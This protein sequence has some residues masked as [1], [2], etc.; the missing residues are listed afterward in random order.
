MNEW[1]EVNEVTE[2]GRMWELSDWVF[3]HAEL[4]AWKRPVVWMFTHGP[5]LASKLQRSPADTSVRLYSWPCSSDLPMN[6]T[7]PRLKNAGKRVKERLARPSPL[8]QSLMNS[9][10]CGLLENLLFQ[11]GGETEST[12]ALLIRIH[13][14]AASKTG[15][16]QPLA[17]LTKA[18]LATRRLLW[19]RKKRFPLMLKAHLWPTTK[20]RPSKGDSPHLNHA[21][22]RWSKIRRCCFRSF[23]SL[24]RLHLQMLFI[25]RSS[26]LFKLLLVLLD[27][28]FV[29]I[30]ASFT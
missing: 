28:A 23:K 14:R 15:S 11:P 20:T 25:Q 13:L 5:H 26:F 4:C 21:H 16:G 12:T 9:Q 19:K 18:P 2:R 8:L 17:C 22:N 27:T 6:T 7:T 10:K 29:I 30:G 24:P 3:V 1:R